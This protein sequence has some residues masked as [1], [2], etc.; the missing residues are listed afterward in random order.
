M[1]QYSIGADN[2]G[3]NPL[4][5]TDPEGLSSVGGSQGGGTSGSSKGEVC[6]LDKCHSD[7]V[8]AQAKCG[9]NWWKGPYKWMRCME[10][11]RGRQSACINNAKL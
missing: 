2:V 7:L 11:A 5:F 1:G 3:Q 8:K 10:D 6:D 4:G 9:E